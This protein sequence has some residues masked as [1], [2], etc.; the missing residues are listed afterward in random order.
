M[1]P[2]APGRIRCLVPFCGRTFKK[3]ACDDKGE[4]MCG[5]HYRLADKSKR[6]RLRVIYRAWQKADAKDMALARHKAADLW[7]RQWGE[8]KVQVIERAMGA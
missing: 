8:I 7:W 6:L 1:K 3:K 4:V 2:L 5:R